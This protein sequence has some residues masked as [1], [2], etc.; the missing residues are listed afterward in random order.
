M[1]Q[2]LFVIFTGT[3][4]LSFNL[5][6]I[7]L[8][9]RWVCCLQNNP[10]RKYVEVFLIN[11]LSTS[12]ST[13]LLTSSKGEKHGGGSIMLPD[14]FLSIKTYEIQETIIWRQIPNIQVNPWRIKRLKLSGIS[15]TLTLESFMWGLCSHLIFDIPNFSDHKVHW[16][17]GCVKKNRTVRQCGMTTLP[18]TRRGAEGLGIGQSCRW[19]V[20]QT[21]Y[22]ILHVYFLFAI[23]R[24]YLEFNETDQ[25]NF[26]VFPL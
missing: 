3:N 1:L 11:C 23:I 16:I 5:L 20:F 15:L 17:I 10:Q 4:I 19:E 25:S 18:R 21:N 26:I 24:L 8:W 9:Y 14:F 7:F 2:K 12:N 13:T 6:F 22:V